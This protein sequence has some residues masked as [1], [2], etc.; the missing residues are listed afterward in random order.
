[1]NFAGSF[2][3]AFAATTAALVP[4]IPVGILVS[5]WADQFSKRDLRR[6]ESERREDALRLVHQ[7]VTYNLGMLETIEEAARTE[8]AV[9]FEP[10][11]NYATWE[12]E[13]DD[14]K[15]LVREPGFRVLVAHHFDGI[16]RLE[17][18]LRTL[19][20]WTVG[21]NTAI[22]TVGQP[23]GETPITIRRHIRDRILRTCVEVNLAGGGILQ[24]LRITDEG[25]AELS[26]PSP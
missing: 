9:L 22:N 16:Q 19:S 17:R 4:G 14:I 23:V 20:E 12:M 2:F 7:A 25:H 24:W 18:L 11:L 5:R 13:G 1:M 10:P 26:R 8:G 3:P 21:L 6:A 15:R